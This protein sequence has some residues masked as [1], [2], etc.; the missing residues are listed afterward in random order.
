MGLRVSNIETVNST[1][2]HMTAKQLWL[3]RL[4]EHLSSSPHLSYEI[5]EETGRSVTHCFIPLLITYC[6][7]LH[8]SF[9]IT[10]S[11]KAPSMALPPL[12]IRLPSRQLSSILTLLQ[13]V[14]SLSLRCQTEIH[15]C[16]QWIEALLGHIGKQMTFDS[17]LGSLQII[18]QG[19]CDHGNTQR[20][21]VA[22]MAHT[23]GK[24][25]GM[26]L[27]LLMAPMETDQS[28]P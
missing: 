6:W 15:A 16:S 14:S 5:W 12:E 13:P 19:S 4:L 2:I 1:Q 22:S 24:S 27:C 9:L 20:H 21:R 10:W 11:L 3:E 23:L 7:P 25:S 28:V 17:I 18:S 26:D 8:P